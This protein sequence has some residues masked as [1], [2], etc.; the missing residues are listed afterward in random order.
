MIRLQGFWLLLA[1]PD[2]EPPGRPEARRSQKPEARSQEEPEARR[3][4]E[5]PEARRSQGKPGEAGK[6]ILGYFG[7]FWLPLAP[8]VDGLG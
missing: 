5:E 3:S 8:L 2:L 6:A 1:P 4:Q 7:L